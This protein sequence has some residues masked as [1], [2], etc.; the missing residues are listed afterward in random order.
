MK[1][2]IEFIMSFTISSVTLAVFVFCNK[3]KSI[4]V[5]PPKLWDSSLEVS[6]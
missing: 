6:Y 2:Y 5:A 1:I 3:S 4:Q